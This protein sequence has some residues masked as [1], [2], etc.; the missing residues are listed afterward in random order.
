M[1][2]L[3]ELPSVD[4]FTLQSETSDKSVAF[5]VGRRTFEVASGQ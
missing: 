2:I 4:V 5:R 3:D 1:W